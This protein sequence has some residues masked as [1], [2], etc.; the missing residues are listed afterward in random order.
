VLS[1]I[2]YLV[3]VAGTLIA[4]R[5]S[6][7][8]NERRWHLVG[9]GLIGGRAL[10][11]AAAVQSLTAS[12][13]ALSLA[14]FGLASMFGP[15]WAL[16]TSSLGG[17]GAAAAIALINSLGNTGDSPGRLVGYIRDA[18]GS[19]AWGLVVV[20]AVLAFVPLLALRVDRARRIQRAEV[21]SAVRAREEKMTQGEAV[22]GSIT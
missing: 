5:H 8:M 16:A 7:R 19:F 22:K 15:F 1:A 13:V 2:P 20:G 4:G 18:T 10:A 3:G 21:A 9:A 17:V 14:M 6:D 12:L 11:A